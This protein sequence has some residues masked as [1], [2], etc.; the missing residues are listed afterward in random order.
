MPR[1]LARCTRHSRVTSPLPV[2]AV[3]QAAG[4]GSRSFPGVDISNISGS[5]AL[6]A[7][8]AGSTA[9][10]GSLAAAQASPA[11]QAQSLRASTDSALLSSLG[12]S[13]SVLPDISG[14]TAAAQAYSL[15]TKPELLQQLAKGSVPDS[16]AR[17]AAVVSAPT[18]AFNPFD[19]G[20]WWT[21]ASL[22]STV[23]TTA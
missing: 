2:T 13:G 11:V 18:Y 6:T 22:G 9:A 12:G 3:T 5:S 15:Y 21:S 23:D 20:S 19:E 7:L 14:L 17:T 8:L 16:G 1:I 4:A 10:S